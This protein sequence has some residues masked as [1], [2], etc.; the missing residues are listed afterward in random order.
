MTDMEVE[1]N[2]Y[3]NNTYSSKENNTININTFGNY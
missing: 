1:P 2:L 3:M